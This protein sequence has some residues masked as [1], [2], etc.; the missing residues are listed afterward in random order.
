MSNR[1]RIGEAFTGML[2]S[3]VLGADMSANAKAR[4]AFSWLARLTQWT[5]MRWDRE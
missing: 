4:S 3:K 1:V 2:R 5:Y